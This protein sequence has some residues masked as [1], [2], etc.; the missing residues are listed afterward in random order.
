LKYAEGDLFAVP[1]RGGG[2]ALGVLARQNR[3]GVL[4]GYFFGPRRGVI[5]RVDDVGPL[6][7]RAAVLVGQFGHLGVKNGSWP[8]LGRTPGWVRDDWPSPP[9]ARF[10]ELTG[11]WFQMFYAD[12]DPNRLLR[13]EPL[14][15]QAAQ[16]LPEDGLMGARF[17]ETRLDR[18]LSEPRLR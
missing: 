16:S 2:Y 5:P 1:V 13:Q 6:N 3:R 12:D 7:A 14:D 8:V 11:R 9:F 4:L 18:L 10:E 17:V 15:A